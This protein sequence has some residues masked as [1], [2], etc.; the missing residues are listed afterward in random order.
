MDGRSDL[1]TR[2]CTSKE[3]MDSCN[4]AQAGPGIVR[5][6]H[7]LTLACTL[8]VSHTLA[9]SHAHSHTHTSCN[10]VVQS[11]STAHTPAPSHLI[12]TNT[13]TYTRTHCVR[14]RGCEHPLSHHVSPAVTHTPT[15]FASHAPP[16]LCHAVTHTPAHTLTL[17][18]IL[19]P[20]TVTHTH[21]NTQYSSFLALTKPH[22]VTLYLTNRDPET[23]DADT[24]LP[25]SFISS[26]SHTHEHA[27]ILCKSLFFFVF[28]V[29]TGLCE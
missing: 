24:P 21:S 28:D 13:H 29:C 7:I 18:L 6:T 1:S 12:C 22:P 5:L 8:N 26:L 23:T 9:Y 17:S 15:T 27:D 3:C 10:S 2:T 25:P 14:E 11:Y 16:S 19:F 20:H 4:H